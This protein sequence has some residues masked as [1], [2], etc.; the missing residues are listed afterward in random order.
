MHKVNKYAKLARQ[1][2]QTALP[3]EHLSFSVAI[4][5][6]SKY[7]ALPKDVVVIN[8]SDIFLHALVCQKLQEVSKAPLQFKYDGKCVFKAAKYGGYSE[9]SD[10]EPKGPACTVKLVYKGDVTLRITDEEDKE[11]PLIVEFD[12]SKVL[13]HT[14]DPTKLYIGREAFSKGL[15]VL[16]S[17]NVYN[18]KMPRESKQRNPDEVLLPVSME[19]ALEVGKKLG[20]KLTKEWNSEE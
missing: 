19:E 7:F 15:L 10:K 1:Q 20:D 3:H 8:G 4:K 9:G 12:A 13:A 11:K 16:K 14:A 18:L 5:G 17:D 2:Y 6:N